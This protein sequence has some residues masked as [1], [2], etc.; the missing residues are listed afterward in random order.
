MDTHAR[1][2]QEIEN[3][4]EV[5]LFIA[6]PPDVAKTKAG[7]PLNL[8]NAQDV[9][10]AWNNNK[11]GLLWAVDTDDGKQLAAYPL[12][13]PPVFDGMAATRGRLFIATADGH[14]LCLS[15]Q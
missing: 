10:N 5:T 1:R 8:S 6:G 9:L 13:S 7:S 14:V 12:D 15:G 2:A 4:L 11:G 3:W